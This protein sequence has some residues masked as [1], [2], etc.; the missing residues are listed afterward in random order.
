MR[1]I[2]E[3]IRILGVD[4][5]PFKPK[6][7][8]KAIL[9]GV[10]YRGG[11]VFD[12]A[13]KAEITVDGMD[14]TDVLVDKINNSKHKK[15]LRVL[16]LHGVTMGGFNLVDIKELNQKTGLPVIIICR[17]KPNL[18]DIR[19]ALRKFDDF[20]GRWSCVENA[21]KIFELEM[22]NNKKVYFQFIGLEKNEVER[23]IKLSCTRSLIPEPLR[24]AHIIAS[25]IIRGESGYR[26]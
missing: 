6:H 14:A 2:K 19:K 13:L 8:G 24:V 12:G 23:I 26:A 3:E 1:E 9:I 22:K 10:I 11:T 18:D 16:M 5:G 17:K 4:D 25:A 21:G 15:Q 20:K 7:H